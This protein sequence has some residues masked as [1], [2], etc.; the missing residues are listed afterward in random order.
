VQ[1]LTKTATTPK[2]VTKITAAV[3]VTD[4]LVVDVITIDGAVMLA[5]VDNNGINSSGINLLGER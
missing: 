2:T 5:V 4:K 1:R 3:A